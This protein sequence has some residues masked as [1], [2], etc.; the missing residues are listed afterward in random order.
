M[1]VVLA[2]RNYLLFRESQS[3]AI[4]WDSSDDESRYPDKVSL[5][6]N[7]QTT[8]TEQLPKTSYCKRANYL[9]KT[10]SSKKLDF[11]QSTTNF[12][13]QQNLVQCQEL[14]HRAKGNQL[15]LIS[16]HNSSNRYCIV[17]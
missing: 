16:K 4:D 3:Q 10:S 17:E 14:I 15:V 12:S 8:T 9:F 5:N 1:V 6:K 11:D 2:L 13:K 7:S